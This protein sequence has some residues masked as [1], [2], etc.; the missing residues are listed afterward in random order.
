MATLLDN[1]KWKRGERN[2]ATCVWTQ[3][4]LS[5]LLWNESDNEKVGGKIKT[6][7]R[8]VTSVTS[9]PEAR[10]SNQMRSSRYTYCGLQLLDK[11]FLQPSDSIVIQIV[12]PVCVHSSFW[13]CLKAGREP[14]R[15]S[16]NSHKDTDAVLFLSALLPL[17]CLIFTSFSLILARTAMRWILDIIVS[18]DEVGELVWV[19]QELRD[20]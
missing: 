13:L 19:I 18:G 2:E 17:C 9:A 10:G 12:E 6:L 14:L 3:K 5:M 1:M 4:L 20:H 8:T 16:T 11:S 15:S 7:V